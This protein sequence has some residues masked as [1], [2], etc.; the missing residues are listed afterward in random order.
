MR[1]DLRQFIRLRQP[2]FFSRSPLANHLYSAL[3]AATPPES[4]SLRPLPEYVPQ[5]FW[6][7]ATTTARYLFTPRHEFVT[8]EKAPSN[9][10]Y[11]V[12]NTLRVAIAGDWGTGTEESFAVNNEMLRWD[13]GQKP[14]LTIHL[15]DVYYV[16]GEKEV[17]QNC[18]DG[19]D[20]DGKQNFPTKDSVGWN[21]GSLGS[22]ALNGNHEMYA[23]GN[24]YFDT[25]LPKLGMLDDDGKPQ[26]QVTSFFCLENDFW[27]ILAIDTGYNS[28][29]W[30]ASSNLLC[31]LEDSLIAWLR[32]LIPANDTKA[33]VLLSH[34]QY[35]SAF[36]DNYLLPVKQL[37]PFFKSPV[38]WIWGHEHRSAGY[39]LFN[40]DGISLQAHGRCIGH[41]G[42]PVEAAEPSADPKHSA[43][44]QKLIYYDARPNTFYTGV[45]ETP[46][47]GINGFAHFSF[48]GPRLT[49]QHKYLVP[50]ST[51]PNPPSYSSAVP[52]I[53][54]S[55]TCSGCQ[56]RWEGF[57]GPNPQIAGLN[58]N[59]K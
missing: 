16:G 38:L 45:G 5:A 40:V 12:P 51:A 18:L 8:A 55:F 17:E 7:W 26:G 58:I 24:A 42:M 11:S 6:D 3:A 56:I 14:H 59:P 52:L 22:F 21:L 34:H 25:L 44:K 23:K 28:A 27:R 46:P 53:T 36:E 48:V 10:H 39:D 35:F 41:G 57:I 33:T 50:D 29:N 20:K 30:L 43:A 37:S 32:T 47:I 54:E 49:I 1:T 2:K 9:S 15:G 19:K 13:G 4:K 31:Q